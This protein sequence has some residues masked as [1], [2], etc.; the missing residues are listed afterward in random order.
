MADSMRDIGLT[1]SGMEKDLRGILMEI[2]T[3]ETLKLV[4]LME[5]ESIPGQMEKYM[6][7]SGTKDLRMGMAF[8]KE[9]IMIHMLESG[10]S[11][12]LMVSE[13]TNGPM[14][15]NMRESGICASSMEQELILFAMG[16]YIPAS[17]WMESL[18]ERAPT[19]GRLDKSIQVSL[20]MV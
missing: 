19:L 2:L 14:A 17:M 13:Y 10:L 3:L 11:Q 5:M 6:M 12:K 1:I 9:L 16:T 8:G 20:K 15:T 18:T 4:K 7:E